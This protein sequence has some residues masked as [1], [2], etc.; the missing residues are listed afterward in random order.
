MKVYVLELIWK[1]EGSLVIGSYRSREKAEQEGNYKIAS[2][3]ADA[4]FVTE[5]EVKDD[6]KTIPKVN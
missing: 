6:Q 3:K 2:C 1:D 5:C 4:Y